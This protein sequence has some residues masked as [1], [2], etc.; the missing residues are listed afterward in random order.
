MQSG[1]VSIIRYEYQ[2]GSVDLFLGNFI[3]KLAQFYIDCVSIKD[4]N[5]LKVKH[6]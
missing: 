1:N 2:R 3:G 4:W 5:C 6:V